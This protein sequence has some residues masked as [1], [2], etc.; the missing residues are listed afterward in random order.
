M[1]QI[2]HIIAPEDEMD[3]KIDAPEFDLMIKFVASLQIHLVGDE[4]VDDGTIIRWK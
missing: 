2:T 1:T 4:A 3:G